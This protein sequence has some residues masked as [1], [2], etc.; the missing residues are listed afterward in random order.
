VG[1]VFF[2][3]VI[4]SDV[5]LIFCIRR[6]FE[7]AASALLDF[8]LFARNKKIGTNDKRVKLFAATNR[9][10]L[11]VENCHFENFGER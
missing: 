7:S 9:A 11:N 5:L 2:A 4:P 10:L 1:N 8:K 3:L 6:E